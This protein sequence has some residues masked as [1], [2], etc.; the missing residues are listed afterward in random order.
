M[1]LHD[2]LSGIIGNPDQLSHLVLYA[3]IPALYHIIYE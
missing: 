3:E 2:S 1:K